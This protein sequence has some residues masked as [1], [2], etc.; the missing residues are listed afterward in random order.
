MK[1]SALLTL[2]L[3]VCVAVLAICALFIFGSS[4]KITYAHAS[5]YTAGG[6]VL[7]TVP[8]ALDVNWLDGSVTIAYHAENTVV[9]SETS[10]RDIPEDMTLR[11]WLDGA[12]LR[13]QYAKNS[14]FKPFTSLNKALTL[15]LPEGTRLRSAVISATSADLIVP[16][17]CAESLK[18]E[19][20]SG[21]VRAS[22]ETVTFTASSTSGD[23]QAALTGA[24]KISATATS[25]SISLTQAGQAAEISASSTSGSVSVQAENAARLTAGT[26]SGA[27]SADAETAGSVKLS[28]TS[29]RVAVRLGSF[30]DMKI[31]TTSGD[32][33]ATLPAA[34]G[35][36]GQI[37]T[38][39]GA[40]ECAQ[41]LQKSGQ[42]YTCG[43]GSASIGI[44]TTS[45]SVRIR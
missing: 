35:Y 22:A 4:L 3:I 9:L 38:T 14:V 21:D 13:V 28:S 41:P 33:D 15:T 5:E 40:I 2:L 10:P 44:H 11:W 43:D 37:T 7:N 32:V 36:S 8:E 42:T 45:G 12:T 25:G 16:D 30:T 6:T 31:D 34:P 17:L 26:T 23:I 29:G 20:T 24:E 19:S 18:L 27:I 1:R 39:S